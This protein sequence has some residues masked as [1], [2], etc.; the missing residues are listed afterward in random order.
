MTPI[1]QA[2]KKQERRASQ[3]HNEPATDS[4][5]ILKKKSQN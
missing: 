1:L 4:L 5:W 2:M 3:E